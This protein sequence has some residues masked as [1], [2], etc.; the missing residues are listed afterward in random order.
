VQPALVERW[1]VVV[2]AAV[3]PHVHLVSSALG[4]ARNLQ[5]PITAV[6]TEV[7]IVTN[8]PC[9]I[10]HTYMHNYPLGPCRIIP[11]VSCNSGSSFDSLVFG[12]RAGRLLWWTARST[13]PY[14]G[15]TYSTDC[16]MRE[17]ALPP[18]ERPDGK[19][20]HDRDVY[21]AVADC[22]CSTA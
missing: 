17:N 20:S 16:S 9:I 18:G 22:L 11:P 10:N 14:T 2:G 5:F 12:A 4:T 19:Q 15:T 3:Q 21:A 6:Q 7:F 13:F 8:H 1:L